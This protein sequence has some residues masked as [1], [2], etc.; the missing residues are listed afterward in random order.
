MAKQVNFFD[1]AQSGT[2]PT[3]GNVDT[4]SLSTYANDAAYE[5]AN[6]PGEE[7]NI[8]SNTTDNVIRYHNGTA[9]G[10]LPNDTSTDTFQNK[11]IDGTDAT[12]NN[13]VTTD[14]DDVSYDNG[15]SGLTA[16]E[17]KAAVDEIVGRLATAEGVGTDNTSDIIDLENADSDTQD[18]LG[19]LPGQDN[20]GNYSGGILTDNTDQATLNQEL[21]NAIE[22]VGSGLAFQGTWNADTNTP[23]L[24]SGV[25]TQGYFYIVSDAGS[26]N[27]DGI[28]DWQ[29]NDWAVFDG[30]VWRKVDNSEI[31]TSVNGQTGTVVLNLNDINDVD[32]TG[33]AA[34]YQ[35]RRNA[36]DTEYEV[37]NADD[38]GN[39]TQSG[40]AIA[41]TQP[42]VR[43]VRATDNGLVSIETIVAG[44]PGQRFTL[45][46]K[47]ATSMDIL[48]ES[49]GVT[50]N[51]ILTGTGAT[52]TLEN[53]GSVDLFY[54]DSS[55]RW[56]VIGGTGGGGGVSFP[57]LGPNGSAAAPTYSFS[58]VTN[59]GM[60]IQGSS[61]SFTHD[62]AS[63]LELNGSTFRPA[64]AMNGVLNLGATNRR[65]ANAYSSTFSVMNASVQTVGIHSE[66]TTPS[67]ITNTFLHRAGSAADLGLTT[68]NQTA[69]S[70]DSK[71]IYIETGN[72]TGTTAD[73]G[74]IEIRV[75]TATGTQGKIELDA[76]IIRVQNLQAYTGGFG[77]GER[78][79]AFVDAAGR[80]QMGQSGVDFRVNGPMTPA[81]DGTLNC[82]SSALRWANV[83]ADQFEG[84]GGIT[85][86]SQTTPSG[87]GSVSG[88]QSSKVV[89][90][91]MWT[92]ENADADAVKTQDVFIETGNKTAGT[93]DSGFINIQTGT[94]TGGTRG[95]INLN[96]EEVNVVATSIDHNQAVNKTLVH[97]SGATGSR[98][99]APVTAQ[100]FFDT[101]LGHPIWF[102]GTTWVDATGSSV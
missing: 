23:S 86:K 102:D 100:V 13:T 85:W 40:T 79:I 73:S 84:L 26:T 46:N 96:C 9:W 24:A 20:M 50:A 37:F 18:A 64:S 17:I 66:G 83:S 81:A 71:S 95:N 65:F 90:T 97:D 32:T 51:R 22:A 82:G 45:V 76:P 62:G 98:P 68:F 14:A 36:G 59:A 52:L 87:I 63:R 61:L 16:T 39:N 56:Q 89:D 5:A 94:S 67:G 47:T 49:G 27:L 1:G 93:G 6:G 42:S 57:L 25:G 38:I 3:V 11:T 35:I 58:G 101:T 12:G 34:R 33:I 4:S 92:G 54:D 69:A 77:A 31:V 91:G 10:A 2:V 43:N 70:T 75:G 72:A 41:L 74:S 53:N 99:G 44:Y 60:Y 15:A 7:G 30:T 28:T 88:I 8:Y 48:N 21:S 80:I 55:S 19:I 29:V 78:S